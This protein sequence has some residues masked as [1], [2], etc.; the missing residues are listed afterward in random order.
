MAAW[1]TRQTSPEP[2]SPAA[3]AGKSGW[4]SIPAE[5]AS[6]T[7]K[8]DAIVAN[9]RIAL[10]ARRQAAAIEI[11]G[12]ETDMPVLRASLALVS[13]DGEPA[14]RLEG[15]ALL[16]HLRGG[17][18]LQ[19]A[20]RTYKGAEVVGRFRLKRGDLAVEVTAG[21]GARRIRVQCPT[22]FVVLPDFFADD[23]LIDA[24]KLPSARAELPSENFLL[25]MAGKGDAI[26]MSV[27]EN[28]EQEVKAILRGEGDKRVFLATEIDFGKKGKK[29]WVALL[30][31]ANM[32]HA[33][34]VKE[35]DAR[36]ILPLDWTMP[37]PAQWRCDFTRSNGLTDS[38]EVLLQEKP[39]GNY[40]K[41]EWMENWSRV[42]PPNRERW[43]TVLGTFPYPCWTDH[44]KKG[45]L[46]PLDRKGMKFGGP[47]VIYPIHRLP[48]TPVQSYTV[49]DVMRH[50]LGVGPCEYI[51]DLEG[52]KES[53]RGVNTCSVRDLFK[54]IYGKGQQKEKRDLIEKKLE[55][56]L[57][58]VTHI[59]RRID[60]YFE[61]RK[62][63]GE[64][65]AAQRKARPDLAKVL[66]E[67]EGI[68]RELDDRRAARAERIRTPEYVARL[69]EDFRK[70]VRDYEGPDALERVA[71]YGSALT[72]VGDNQDELVGECRWAVKTLRQRAGLAMALDPKATPVAEEIRLRC[73][74]ILRNP[75]ALERA[76]R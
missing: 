56:A 25:Q 75:S 76:H 33:A 30:E 21:S 45:Y 12:M 42:I 32:W 18:A 3:L 36:K 54:E 63:I 60:A 62:A 34:Q 24:R 46:Q 22:R 52:Q 47:A 74:K 1:D 71:K 35:A 26:M 9:G 14:T 51:L 50:T 59:R 72:E 7:F 49:V 70:N 5:K 44:D 57:I 53:N 40:L 6:A 13:A 73:Q 19:A 31:G 43:T 20:F 58:F 17:A 41:P 37:F 67:A 68:L 38:W 69:N 16:E 27:F 4:K 61:F 66:D 39:G 2:L 55:E 10:V 8:G 48:K 23:I 65:V 15:A 28:R 64:Y 29:V 11:Y